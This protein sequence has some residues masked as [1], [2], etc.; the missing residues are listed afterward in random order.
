MSRKAAFAINIK[1]KQDI[2]LKTS[3]H[4][5]SQIDIDSHYVSRKTYTVIAHWYFINYIFVQMVC[6]LRDLQLD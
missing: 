3:M 4:E 2:I 6:G 1:R 5:S